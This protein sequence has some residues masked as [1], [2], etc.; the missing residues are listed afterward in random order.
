MVEK[1]VFTSLKREFLS[2]IESQG[3]VLKGDR[4]LIGLSGGPDSLCLL[5]LFI[6]IKDELNLELGACHVNHGIRKG[7]CDIEQT[8]V[9]EWCKEWAIPLYSKKADCIA[10]A[11][12]KG[13][14]TEEM[15]RALR[16]EAYK[17][18]S[19]TLFEE[20]HKVK[21]AL[22]HHRDD[23]AETI[24]MRLLRGT[25][26]DG[27][28]GMDYE[29]K[30]GQLFVI[31]PLLDFSKE[32]IREYLKDKGLAP[33]ED[34]SNY[35]AIYFRNK[36]RLNLLPLLKEEY[37]PNITEALLRLAKGAKEDKE[38]FQ[39]KAEDAL[40]NVQRGEKKY[41]IEGLLKLEP[42][43]R[44]RVLVMMLE[45]AGLIQDYTLS[46]M[47]QITELLKKGRKGGKVTL[48]YG[49][50]L[51]RGYEEIFFHNEIKEEKNLLPSVEEVLK[52]FSLAEGLVIRNREEGDYL[53]LE[54]GGRKKLQDY[55]VDE[56]IERRIRGKIL[57]IAKGSEVIAVLG[58][59]I[60]IKIMESSLEGFT[61]CPKKTRTGAG[62]FIKFEGGYFQV[63]Q[64]G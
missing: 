5:Q 48:P 51:E 57:L 31:R 36:I 2:I 55:M 42:A 52:S 22:A 4:I 30:E 6:E 21:V 23:Q 64:V 60:L 12:E 14:S 50:T 11:E 27:L 61:D 37:N 15:G 34:L 25:G 20:E 63:E 53:P 13:L 32:T 19:L 7:V 47:D 8:Q 44:N 45:E 10:L 41:E 49:L 38:Y 26:P 56:K 18:A 39:K 17:E 24:L 58:Q 33:H 62:Y 59:D 35:E 3:L 16:Y 28:S 40:G 46:H 54:K 29:R 9:E 1:A 43:L